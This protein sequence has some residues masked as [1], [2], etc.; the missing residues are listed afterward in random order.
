M[1]VDLS[2][3]YNVLNDPVVSIESLDI[4][5][6]GNFTLAEDDA[7]SGYL[8]GGDVSVNGNKFSIESAPVKTMTG[9]NKKL[10][11]SF[12]LKSADFS[13]YGSNI[14]YSGNVRYSLKLKVSGTTRVPPTSRGAQIS[15]HSSR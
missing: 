12:Y 4:I 6:P 1:D 5:F 9:G 8:N 10:P 11:V 14:D 3:I 13:E 15:P 2:G 7:L